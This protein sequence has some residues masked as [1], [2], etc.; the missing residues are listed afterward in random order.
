MTSNRPMPGPLPPGAVLPP[1]HAGSGQ[2]ASARPAVPQA[3]ASRRQRGQPLA[4]P[5]KKFNRVTDAKGD[6]HLRS[7]NRFV[8]INAFV[9]ITMRELSDRA[10]LAWLVLWRDTKPNGLARTAVA[11]LARRMGCSLS[12]AKRALAELRKKNLIDVPT[13]G[14]L[15]RGPSS[16]RL[17]D[18]RTAAGRELGLSSAQNR[19]SK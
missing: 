4:S 11:D 14:G 18:T 9:D 3:A 10:A 2:H 17:A 12:K 16:Y 15:G 7:G 5:P 6:G 1:I 19:G 13:R 8:T